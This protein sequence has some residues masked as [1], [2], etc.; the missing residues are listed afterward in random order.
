MIP[1]Q[2]QN[3]L[4]MESGEEKK[5]IFHVEGLGNNGCHYF[6]GHIDAGSVK[7]KSTPICNK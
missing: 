7:T 2:F 3:F 1:E 4:I 6:N 5:H